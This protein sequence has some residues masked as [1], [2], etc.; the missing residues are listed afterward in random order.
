MG[1]GKFQC[2]NN[3][4]SVILQKQTQE[5]YVDCLLWVTEN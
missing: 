5:R 4:M 1:F 3:Q 2:I